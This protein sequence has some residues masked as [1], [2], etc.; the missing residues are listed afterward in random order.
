MA[1]QASLTLRNQE[2]G[3][4]LGDKAALYQVTA[5]RIRVA[6]MRLSADIGVHPEEAATAQDLI[7]DVTLDVLPPPTDQLSDAVD[8]TDIESKARWLASTRIGLI[9]TFARRLA[10]QCLDHSFV[11]EAEVRVKKPGALANG[12]ASAH[13]TLRKTE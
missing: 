13:I 5:S 8:Y 10:E 11:I 7:V 1:A 4:G 12:L 6:D 9:E 2:Q 3:V